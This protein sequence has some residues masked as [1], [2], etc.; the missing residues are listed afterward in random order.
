MANIK[1]TFTIFGDSFDPTELSASLGKNDAIYWYKG[2]PSLGYP[3]VLK[4][5]TGWEY[6]IEMPGIHF[7]EDITDVAI[8]RLAEK[9][10][11]I[12]EYINR[13]HL[14]AKFFIVV[15]ILN[16][17]TPSLFINQ[18]LIDFSSSIKAELD[19]DLYVILSRGERTRN[20]LE[21]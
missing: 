9:E 10:H 4:K 5:E 15:K 19:I 14:R 8:D 21:C 12:K 17:E 16:K 18:K 1:L 6:S 7:L 13:N 2:D 20:T 11:F 3:S